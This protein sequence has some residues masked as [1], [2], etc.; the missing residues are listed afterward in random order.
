MLINTSKIKEMVI[1]FCKDKTH[2]ESLPRININGSDRDRVNEVKVLGLNILSDLSCNEHVDVIVS[3]ASKREY[4]IYQL[5]RTDI[6]QHD[7][8]EFNCL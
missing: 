8:L 6:K 2:V 7:F 1:C 3:R 4:M 5:K